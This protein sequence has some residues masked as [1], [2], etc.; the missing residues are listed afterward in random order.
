VINDLG[1]FRARFLTNSINLKAR[2]ILSNTD[3]T[4]KKGKLVD[5]WQEAWGA[6]HA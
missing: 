6:H 5:H 2:G 4:E 1:K 3:K